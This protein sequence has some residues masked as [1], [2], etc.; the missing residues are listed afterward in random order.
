M[1][2]R[3]SFKT[4]YKSKFFELRDE[5]CETETGLT[6]PKY[7]VIDFP[8]WVQSVALNDKDEL[9]LVDQ[10]RYPGVGNFLEFP[11]GSSDPSRKEDP[12]DAAKREL[13]EETGYES[14]DWSSIGFHYP[15][16]ALMG[17]RCHVYIAKNC[18]KTSELNL[19]PYEFLTVKTYNI[20]DFEKE[21]STSKKCHSLM[22]ATWAMART[23][24][25]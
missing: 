8:D 5:V 14:N 20:Q 11:G 4:V 16:P 12:M 7:Y 13:L 19:D 6:V 3:K 10:Y 22:L 21:I 25:C 2:K 23:K 1:W 24:I 15:N 9:I 18:I 17:N